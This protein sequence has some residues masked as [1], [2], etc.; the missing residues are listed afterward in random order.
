MIIDSHCHLDSCQ[1]STDEIVQR[2]TERGVGKILTVATDL[3]VEYKAMLALIDHYPSVYGAC[4]FHPDTLPQLL[5][6]IE[7]MRPYYQHKKILAV[8]EI[9]LDYHG[10]DFDKDF[11][12]KGF[13]LQLQLAQELD[14]PVIIH[15]RDAAEDTVK[16]I[17]QAMKV[18]P[19]RG[20]IHCL[21]SSIYIAQKAIEWGFYLSLSGVLTFK[22]ADKLREIAKGLPLDRLLVETDS[23]YLAPVPHRGHPNEPAFVVDTFHCLAELKDCD[24]TTLENTLE[25]NFNTL[26]FKEMI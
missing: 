10:P 7:S 2:A 14:L 18:K 22:N 19:L 13:A 17:E 11:Q 8:G 4:G 6:T 21:P 23:P 25:R 20:V 16:I 9:G 5:P 12:H 1:G 15:T 3:S 24:K 26:F